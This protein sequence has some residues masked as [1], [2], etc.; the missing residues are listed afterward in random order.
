MNNEKMQKYFVPVVIAAAVILVALIGVNVLLANPPK[1]APLVDPKPVVAVETPMTE[2]S[3]EEEVKLANEAWAEANAKYEAEKKARE[4]AESE[5]DKVKTANADVSKELEKVK[6]DYNAV[7]AKLD[8]LQNE[9]NKIS[10]PKLDTL[11]LSE[12]YTS[13][14]KL[15]TVDYEFN[16]VKE[17]TLESKMF[18]KYKIPIDLGIKELVYVIPGKIQLAV[19]FTT[20]KDG[21]RIDDTAKTITITIPMAFISSIETFDDKAKRY[22]V[23]DGLISPEIDDTYRQVII[24]VKAERESAIKSAGMLAQAQNLAGYQIKS[25]LEPI[26]SKAGYSIKIANK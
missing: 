12:K 2:E 23:K 19:D 11:A 15:V 13:V 21:M 3:W 24:D 14:G 9:Y 20:V 6:G 17:V 10:P 22:S 1:P 16:E 18:D 26:A 5:R 4:E 7:L 25:L 8:S